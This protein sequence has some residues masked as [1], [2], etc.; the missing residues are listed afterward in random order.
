MPFQLQDIFSSDTA[1][2]FEK[3]F[4]TPTPVQ[5]QAWPAIASGQHTLVSAPT[6]TGKTLSA[7]LVFLD[8]L[9]QQARAGTLGQAL[10]LIY[11]S[12]L[13][14]L[15]S[16]IREN[17]KKP[18]AGI[19][20]EI[21]SGESDAASDSIQIN[22]SLRTGDTP[23]KERA[24]M[25]KSPPHILITTPESFYLMLTSKS[26]KTIL[27]TA[28]A[29]VIDE[30]HALIDAKRGA[31]L[32]LSIARLDKLCPAPLQRI[33]L[34]ATIRPLETAAAYLSP[35]PVTIAAPDMQKDIELIV[36]S[37]LPDAKTL[38]D[39]SIWPDLANAVV[40]HCEGANSVIAFV[41]G[42]LFAEKLAYYVN[43]ITEKGFART[44]HGSLSKEQRLE[45]EQAL[46]DGTLKLLCA[47]SSMEL[48]ID[49]GDID[50]VLQIGC[51]LS[52]SSTLQ[53]LGR[54]G[55]NPGR[56][57]VMHIFPRTAS[58][59]LYCGLMAQAARMGQMEDAHPPRQCLDI[60]AQHLVSM[61]AGE[62]Y[63][64]DD[65]L[66]IL[67]RAYPFTRVTKEDVES[68][69]C[70]LAGD[71][72][73]A[74]D[75]PV[76][77]RLLYDRIHETVEGDAYSRMLA[78][79]AGGTIP[80]R[81][82]YTV[83]T[84]DGVK[85]GELDEEFVFEARVG[86]SFMLGT[87]AWRITSI[88]KDDVIVTASA[89]EG[90]QMPFWKGD[91][92]GRGIRAGLS[93]GATLRM[94]SDAY[95]A[96]TL[97]DAL[98]GL[99]LDEVAAL[100]AQDFLK[101]QLLCS[102]CLPDDKT[103][104]VERFSDD[105]GNHKLM[106]HSVFGRRVNAPLAVLAQEAAHRLTG[107]DIA[108]YDDEYGFLM[109]PFAEH[110]LPQRLL[111]EIRPDSA[112][113]I[114]QSLLPMTSLFS[115]TF[116]YNAAH[117]L[118]MG[119]RKTG[120]QPLWVQRLRS[121][122][123]LDALVGMEQHPLI[124][125]TKRECLE[126]YWDIAGVEY[127]LNGIQSGTIRVREVA[128]DGP[129]PM[130]LQ[131]R[132]QAESVLLYETHIPTKAASAAEDAL[133]QAELIKPGA[134][135][136]A[137]VSARKR[138]PADEKQLHSLLM[139][140]GD[141]V[142]GELD[143]PLDWL[144]QLLQQG[145]A[146]Y[147]E[148]GLWIAAEHEADYTAALTEGDIQARL[149]IVRRLLRYRGAQT[150]EQIAE[151]YAWNSKTVQSLLDELILQE[152]VVESD[153]L[154]YHSELFDRARRE[155]VKH[156]RMQ[157]R[158]QP[159]ERYAALLTSRLRTPAPPMEQLEHALGQLR[160]QAY[161]AALWES[162][163]LPARVDG[164]RPDLLDTL[165]S[166]GKWYWQ[167]APSAM[168][169]FHLYEQIDYD[170][171][172][173]QVIETLEGNEQI[174]YE[175]LLKRGASFMPALSGTLGGESPHETLMEL[176]VKGLVHAD[177]FAPVRHLLSREKIKRAPVKQRVRARVTSMLSG[178][179]EIIRPQR[180]HTAEQLLE[181]AFDSALL[182]CR[183]TVQGIPWSAALELLRVWEY[184]GQARRGYYIEGLSGAQFIRQ[185][186]F[187]MTVAALEHPDDAIV[188]LCAA[189]PAQQWGK[190][191]PHMED[192]S[193]LN[194]PGTAV[195]LRGGVPVAV[196]ERQGQVLRVFDDTRLQEALEIFASDFTNRRLF[197]SLLRVTVKQYPEE[198]AGP[199]R[200]AGF[201]R[202]T[203]D[204]T[205]YR[206]LG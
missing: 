158:T 116:R 173:T 22:V 146:N 55:H 142:A 50:R 25:I 183:E 71:Y 58:E 29:V 101:R 2:W 164:Y 176:S 98:R 40:E 117:A 187:S 88:Q 166:Q 184:T 129:S 90:A 23:A 92:T 24:R 77:P 86:D 100:D 96:G 83:K 180:P 120:R 41:Q 93:F 131:L 192:R 190:S 57:S 139:A 134:E 154:Y 121:A 73:H 111:Y 56:V 8:Q 11:I 52:V 48:G 17:L 206:R 44:H 61:A 62:A 193:F 203:G 30:L 78:I 33:G 195:A 53:R 126:D 119:V 19:L 161:P 21:R 63:T 102:G 13:K 103:I 198:S 141:L 148:P 47:T 112:R 27:R 60:L 127:V 70:M 130:S 10:Q 108:C 7:F 67:P 1:R 5:Q 145:R 51:P 28:R 39:G 162:V 157:I 42:R 188:W 150:S 6:G 128:L 87:F 15:A 95:A 181:R 113:Q 114:L 132:R 174:L 107:M 137:K 106:I 204:F 4:G 20:H 175:A 3:A 79:S 191:I 12:P 32:M 46:R 133:K 205:L 152:T 135:Q 136:L 68:L 64:V 65:V 197:P 138:L 54:A 16:D 186:D 49:V 160:G 36:T 172:M 37:P 82:L 179:W 72:E 171:D 122:N 75:I 199:L 118:M 99:G 155:T 34:S 115:L 66:E 194:V 163:L 125:E 147:I 196:F 178:R 170:A 201:S 81:G 84:Q 94:L 169:C 165:L 31:H 168:L 69:L 76:R 85:L 159:P 123:M 200:C 144:E 151:R 43:R 140:E 97:F 91:W 143:I 189:D 104:V 109:F 74:Q 110:P 105:T 202:Q 26:G 38:P 45:V 124:R 59:G 149:R 182:L 9:T 167:L 177:S 156:R 80:D 89:A 18:L 35:D 14:S 153:E 185:K